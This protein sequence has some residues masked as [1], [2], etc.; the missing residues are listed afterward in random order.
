MPNR[1]RLL[2]CRVPFESMPWRY[3]TDGNI[4]A[5]PDEYGVDSS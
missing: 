2:K 3:E 1:T 4:C 5:G